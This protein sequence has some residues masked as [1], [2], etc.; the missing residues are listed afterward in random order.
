MPR[1]QKRSLDRVGRSVSPRRATDNWPLTTG[2]RPLIRLSAPHISL[3]ASIRI[4]AGRTSARPS[5]LN[6]SAASRD[7]RCR[8]NNAPA[9]MLP[10][11]S[12]TVM[13]HGIY[14][15]LSRRI[16]RLHPIGCTTVDFRTTYGKA[17]QP[18]AVLKK[19]P[20]LTTR[21]RGQF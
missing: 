15:I 8:R 16:H 20:V 2:H 6:L 1:G 13:K 10:F 9:Q 5:Q 18:V 21:S 17:R 12:K 11:G 7:Q 14:G 19:K 4:P 3:S